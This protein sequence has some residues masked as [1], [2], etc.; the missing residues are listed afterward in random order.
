MAVIWESVGVGEERVKP[1]LMM[2]ILSGCRE[3]GMVRC[4]EGSPFQ[5]VPQRCTG[6]RGASKSSVPTLGVPKNFLKEP[7]ESGR[8]N[9]V[10]GL[11]L[12]LAAGR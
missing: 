12:N 9:S 6:V 11:N 4:A 3:G 8:V 10:A 5:D 2:G 7:I 1:G